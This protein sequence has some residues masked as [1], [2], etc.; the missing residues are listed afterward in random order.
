MS[1]LSWLFGGKPAGAADAKRR[2]KRTDAAKLCAAML[3]ERRLIAQVYAPQG[4]AGRVGIPLGLPGTPPRGL[5]WIEIL[6]TGEVVLHGNGSSIAAQLAPLIT[7][8]VAKACANITIDPV[9]AD[10]RTWVVG[11]Y[12]V[13]QA[14]TGL[15]TVVGNTDGEVR[16][17]LDTPEAAVRAAE[18]ASWTKPAG[19]ASAAAGA[20]GTAGAP[21]PIAV[22]MEREH[23]ARWL[24]S[25]LRE[26]GYPARAER[27]VIYVEQSG[28][29]RRV[30]LTVRGPVYEGPLPVGAREALEGA[31]AAVRVVDRLR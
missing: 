1:A 9:P 17:A 21:A 14:P 3:L 10:V 4:D 29:E 26:R 15:W 8:I 16:A 2:V 11:A 30:D 28:E 6:L 27:T 12:R 7:Q 31:L 23:A 13:L 24:A 25:Y 22:E 19:I 18:G 5:G 20:A